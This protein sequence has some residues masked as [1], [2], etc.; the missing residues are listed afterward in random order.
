MIGEE[1]EFDLK[2]INKRETNGWLHWD[3]QTTSTDE[4]T[5]TTMGLKNMMERW[6][7][8]GDCPELMLKKL[9][10]WKQGN[11]NIED[12]ITE[13]DNLKLLAKISNDHAM[14]IL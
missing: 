1:E 10:E 3:D 12:F 4:D 5:I 9:W 11:K 14:E 2:L 13:F 6:F 7:T 8:Q